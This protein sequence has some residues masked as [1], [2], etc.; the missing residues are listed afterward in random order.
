MFLYLERHAARLQ[1][2][3]DGYVESFVLV[4]QGVVVSI[5]D[6]TP[7]ELA[8]LRHVDIFLNEIR[9]EVFHQVILSFKIHYRPLRAFLVDEHYRR[10]AGL[11]GHVGVVGTEVRSYMH[12]AGT[13]V[14]CDI[15]PRY[16]AERTVRHRTNH[17][18]QLLVPHA[19][20]VGSLV[21]C[22]NIIRYN[23]VSF[24]I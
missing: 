7:G 24:L 3:T 12:D 15:I 23:L 5:L 4:G 11:L 18:H 13:V 1:V 21:M 17:R 10:H 9:I 6:I 19:Y 8:P 14:G 16:H 22:D 20:K 2:H